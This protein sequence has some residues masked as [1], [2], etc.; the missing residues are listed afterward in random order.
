MASGSVVTFDDPTESALVA[1]GIASTSAAALTAGNLTVNMSK[2]RAVI[3]AGSA[4]VTVTCAQCVAASTVLAM[5]S[6]S[7]ADGTATSI[8][9]VAPAAGSF[10][11]TANAAATANTQVDWAVLNN[12]GAA[13][14]IR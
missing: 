1:Q 3:A 10:V 2:G 11:I 9:R 4:A 8:A 6:Q 7:A 12:S 14:L 13:G 5:I